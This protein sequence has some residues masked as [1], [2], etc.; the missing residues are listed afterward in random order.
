MSEAYIGNVRIFSFSF[1]PKGWAMCNGQLLQINQNQALFALLG[2]N[3]GGD[4]RTT[5]ALPD[6]RGRA[7][8]HFGNGPGLSTYMQ[9][10]STGAETVTLGVTQLPEHAHTLKVSA[11][12]ASTPAPGG[13]VLATPATKMF[14]TAS[15]TVAMNSAA[16]ASAGSSQPHENRQ[17]YLTLNF[18]IALNGIFPSRN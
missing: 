1:A 11:N 8:L 2:T 13:N 14:A 5:F 17:P 10:E 3:Y 12:A 6:L 16:I 4:G 15:N 18:C 9:G 7:P